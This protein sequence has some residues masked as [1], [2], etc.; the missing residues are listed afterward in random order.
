MKLLE[1]QKKILQVLDN[2]G[3]LIEDE[4]VYNED[5]TETKD[6]DLT[7]YILDSLQFI[8]FLI[9]LEQC[10]QLEMPEDMLLYDNLQSFGGFSRRL[11]TALN[12]GG[13]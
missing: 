1:V 5:G 3:I 11:L 6:F 13:L 2:M 12:E 8:T 9:D 7:E 4:D 10:F